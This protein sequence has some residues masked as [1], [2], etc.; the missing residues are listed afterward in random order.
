MVQLY[1]PYFIFIKIYDIIFIVSKKGLIF[2][3]EEH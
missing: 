1:R 2:L 3:W